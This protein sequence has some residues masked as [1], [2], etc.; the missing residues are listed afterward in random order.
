MAGL[1]G[2]SVN[3]QFLREIARFAGLVDEVTQCCAT[4]FDR[5]AQHGLRCLDEPRQTMFGDASR[6]SLRMDSGKKQRLAA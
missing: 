6:R 3:Q 4:P 1:A 2:A 5:C